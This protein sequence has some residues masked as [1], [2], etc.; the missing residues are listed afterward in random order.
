VQATFKF[1]R[2]QVCDIAKSSQ[3][4]ADRLNIPAGGCVHPDI[5]SYVNYRS[6]KG[7]MKQR[8]GIRQRAAPSIGISRYTLVFA[9]L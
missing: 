8:N 4:L 6:W 7:I 3:L 1:I 9:G 5:C 2:I